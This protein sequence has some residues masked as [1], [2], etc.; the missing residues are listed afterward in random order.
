MRTLVERYFEAINGEDWDGLA[1]VL[2]PDV[3]IHTTGAPPA[4]GRD[5][6]LAHF[7]TVLAGYPEHLDAVT[8][9]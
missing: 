7:R 5:A 2:A 8:R 9:S 1:A 4:L 6:A 3:E